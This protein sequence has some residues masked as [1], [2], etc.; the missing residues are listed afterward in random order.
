MRKSI[1][2]LHLWLSVP[3]GLIITALCL[4]GAALVFEK[5][6]S[7]A[8]RPS[9][10]FVEVP[11]AAPLPLGTLAEQVSATLP[12]SVTIG[13]ITAFSDP[14]RAYQVS[15]A[16]NRRTSLYVNPYTGEVTGLYERAPFFFFMFRLHRWL[17][18]TVKYDGSGGIAWGK[19]IVGV[20]TLAFVFILI[21]GV[22]VWIPRNRKMLRNRLRV[23]RHKGWR[24]LWYDLHVSVGIYVFLFLLIMS[25]TG[26]TWSFGWYRTGFYKLFGVENVANGGHGGKKGVKGGHVLY[27]QWQHIYAQLA[28]ANP[29]YAQIAVGEGTASV[30]FNRLGNRLAADRYKFNNRTGEITE[31]IPYRNSE[32]SNKLFGWIYS[33]HVGSFGGTI[34]R[35]IWFLAALVGA[36]LP[37]TGY[38][39]WLKRKRWPHGIFGLHSPSNR[40][41][42]P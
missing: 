14:A 37:L 8:A 7:E 18:D 28:A 22:W 40:G 34:T 41:G 35:I 6:I 16:G 42:V 20:S 30:T 19:T 26:L 36:S 25:L 27:E 15:L 5:E 29:G 17:L 11:H 21:S 13:T 31:V 4:S 2:Q 24:R 12:D 32:K 39:L 23:E 1:K 3:V 33:V 9:L 38:Y 10:Y